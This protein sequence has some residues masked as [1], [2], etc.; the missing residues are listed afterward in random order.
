MESGVGVQLSNLVFLPLRLAPF[1][2]STADSADTHSTTYT[3]TTGQL[4]SP[5]EGKLTGL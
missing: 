4:P 2:N 1:H 5:R 3:L